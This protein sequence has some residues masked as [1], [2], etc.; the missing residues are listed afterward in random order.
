MIST[1]SSGLLTYDLGLGVTF[2]ALQR[3]RVCD[4]DS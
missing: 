3:Q 2:E 1:A 4:I